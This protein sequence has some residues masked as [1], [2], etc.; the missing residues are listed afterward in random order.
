MKRIRKAIRILLYGDS[1][2]IQ[3]QIEQRDYVTHLLMENARL[4]ALLEDSRTPRTPAREEGP[5]RIGR[6]VQMRGKMLQNAVDLMNQKRK[7]EQDAVRSD[8]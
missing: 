8:W 4:W 2:C 6:G 1:D 3:E 5:E 7:E